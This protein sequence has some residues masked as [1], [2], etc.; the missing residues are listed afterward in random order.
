MHFT[1][2]VYNIIIDRGICENVVSNEMVQKLNLKME[3]HPC[4][5]K[6]SWF[7][8]GNEVKVD[9]Q[10][11]VQFFIGSKYKDEVLCDVVP[12]DACHILLGGP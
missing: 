3:K 12:M 1:G 9:K 5:Y 7:R 6:L 4:P 10:C 11:L 2:K 8:K